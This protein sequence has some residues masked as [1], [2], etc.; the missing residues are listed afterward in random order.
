MPRPR[1]RS[2]GADLPS[3][4]SGAAGESTAIPASGPFYR[5]TVVAVNYGS[6][7]GIIRTGSGHDATDGRDLCGQ[8]DS[9]RARYATGR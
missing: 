2:N 5:G 7:N 9:H 1:E 4:A 8:F 6:G 3:G